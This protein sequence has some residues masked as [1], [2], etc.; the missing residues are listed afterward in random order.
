VLLGAATVISIIKNGFS[1]DLYGLPAKVLA[2]YIWLRETMF[3]PVAW[4]ARH[5]GI[6]IAS[7]IKD[8]IVAYAVLA[9]PSQG[10]EGRQRSG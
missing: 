3:A 1:I 5:F 9:R 8:M 4:V 10:Y 6:E 2:Q 7:W